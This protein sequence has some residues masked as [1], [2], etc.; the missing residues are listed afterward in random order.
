MPQISSSISPLQMSAIISIMASIELPIEMM[1]TVIAPSSPAPHGSWLAAPRR[2]I[3]ALCGQHIPA[4]SREDVG[5][6]KFRSSVRQEE[7]REDRGWE[8]GM[9]GYH[10]ARGSVK[11]KVL[12]L[13]S[14]ILSAR[15]APCI[16]STRALAMVSPI[17]V[18][19]SVRVRDFSTR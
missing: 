5:K 13:P 12:P 7:I 19:P 15:M 6:V 10:S 1:L 18:P 14:P 16:A 2:T 9:I 4:I 3:S 8:P 11:V 17:P